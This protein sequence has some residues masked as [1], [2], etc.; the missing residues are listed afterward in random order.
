M[1][2]LGIFLEEYEYTK[3]ATWMAN[4]H[5]FMVKTLVAYVITIF[6]I[7]LFMRDRKPFYLERPL[8]LWNASLSLFSTLGVIFITPALYRVIRD[9][10]ISRKFRLNIGFLAFLEFYALDRKC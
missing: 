3:M 8:T 7:K 2:N 1:V 5:S 4:E 6:G 9:H 10:G